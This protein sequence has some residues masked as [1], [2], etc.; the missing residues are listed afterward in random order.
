M[1]RRLSMV[2]IAISSL[3]TFSLQ[4]ADTTSDKEKPSIERKMAADIA[5][6]GLAPGN[7]PKLTR[8]NRQIPEVEFKNGSP[9][10]METIALMGSDSTP[11]AFL[12]SDLYEVPSKAL[13]YLET[14]EIDLLLRFSEQ[15][16][17]LPN[18]PNNLEVRHKT[19]GDGDIFTDASKMSQGIKYIKDI[20][21]EMEAAKKDGQNVALLYHG[22][23]KNVLVF[24]ICNSILGK[25]K[26]I[27]KKGLKGCAATTTV[28]TTAAATT[29][30]STTAVSTTADDIIKNYIKQHKKDFL[31][32]IAIE[33]IKKTS[34]KALSA[35]EIAALVPG[36]VQRV[37]DPAHGA[38]EFDNILKEI[39]FKLAFAK[40]ILATQIYKRIFSDNRDLEKDLGMARLNFIHSFFVQSLQPSAMMNASH[41]KTTNRR[42]PSWSPEDGTL[43]VRPKMRSGSFQPVNPAPNDKQNAEDGS[44]PVGPKTRSSGI[45][46]PVNPISNDKPNNKTTPPV[47]TNDKQD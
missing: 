33:Y 2:L 11:A 41:G 19:S 38:K 26:R 40:E 14:W 1:K 35:T 16:M 10:H 8:K 46:R 34:K 17:P 43:H 18:N 25:T 5:V 42:S 12:V 37:D 22:D 36:V 20:N 32:A 27:M 6:I 29:A 9:R 3:I 15:N 39:D 47:M 23:N 4:A 7:S 30:V 21:S 45:Y 44:S 28:A 24:L 13:K 31:N